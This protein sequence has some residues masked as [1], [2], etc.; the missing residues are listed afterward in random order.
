MA[1][2]EG[3]ERR[4]QQITPFLAKYGIAS[5]EEAEKVCMGKALTFG[6]L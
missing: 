2:F 4:I 3:Y 1:I 6:K 5:L